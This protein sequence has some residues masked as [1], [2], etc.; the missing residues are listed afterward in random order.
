MNMEAVTDRGR[1]AVGAIA[2]MNYLQA[3]IARDLLYGAQLKRDANEYGMSSLAWKF[4]IEAREVWNVIYNG[5]RHKDASLILACHRKRQ[6]LLE[7]SRAFTKK[8]I[9]A[10]YRVGESTVNQVAAQIGL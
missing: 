7:E 4:E 3:Q 9:K 8:A 5:T 1:Q 2:G 10:R 6:D